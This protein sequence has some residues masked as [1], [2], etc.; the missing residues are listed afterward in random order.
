MRQNDYLYIPYGNNEDITRPCL[1]YDGTY[2]FFKSLGID[3]VQN[4]I[5]KKKI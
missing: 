4:F 5:I 1:M 2:D 3:E